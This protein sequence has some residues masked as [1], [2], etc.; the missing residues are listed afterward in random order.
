MPCA[1]RNSPVRRK[2]GTAVYVIRTYGGVR[3]REPRGSLLL[4]LAD[5][6]SPILSV[7]SVSQCCFDSWQFF[8]RI[9][10]GE[11]LGVTNGDNFGRLRH[12]PARE[13]TLVAGEKFPDRTCERAMIKAKQRLQAFAIMA[14]HQARGAFRQQTLR[15]I[16][17]EKGGGRG[18]HP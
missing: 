10:V 16:G 1:K 2:A 7:A 5:W 9:Q 6:C 18:D 12:A 17:G 11:D 13:L 3:G 4:D 15:Q 8:C 14:D